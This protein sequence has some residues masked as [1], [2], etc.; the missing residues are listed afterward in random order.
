M[1]D[2]WKDVSVN[3]NYEINFLGDIRNK[4]TNK[5][6]KPNKNIQGYF[7]IVLSKNNIQKGY[8]VHRLVGLTFL[9]N[10]YN[11]KTINH[12]NK[13][14]T[15]NRLWNL[16]WNTMKE[17]NIHKNIDKVNTTFYMCTMK[18]IWRIDIKTNERLEKYNNLTEAQDW[19]IKNNLSTSK[20]VKN[21]ISLSALGNRNQALGYKWQYEIEDEIEN[22]NEIWKIIPESLINGY[23][24][25]YISSFGRIKY[26][27]NV[28]GN[29]YNFS[30]YLGMS[31]GGK[32]Y[33][34]HRLIAQTF[35]PNPDNKLVV[36][37]KDGDKLNCKLDNLEW[38]THKEN[39]DHAYI[40]YLNKNTKQIIL[41]DK[42]MNKIKDFN[43][44]NSASRELNISSKRIS[45]CCNKKINTFDD[46]IFLFKDEY[47]NENENVFLLPNKQKSIIQ[48]DLNF[49]IIKV[50]DSCSSASEELNINKTL[51]NDC[52]NKKQQTS[53]GFIFMYTN[54]Y[55]PSVKYNLTIKTKAKEIVQLDLN[56]NKIQS[57]SSIIKA[58]SELNL[59]DSS[60][61]LCC[62][63]KRQTAGGFKFM[64]I[65]DYNK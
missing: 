40:T 20:Y 14:K 64:Y 57:F 3:S 13:I 45:N 39:S 54:E 38:N 28:I 55:N 36:N 24:N 18:P 61:S 51:I 4:N 1:Y 19:C 6:L 46:Y 5:I 22:E 27:D 25:I 21:G 17:Q 15:D 48:F 35:L 62:K 33:K 42:N 53:K 56:M 34:A 41:F 16:E 60:I 58:A 50:F 10:Y 9:P 30:G 52:C 29:G 8:L 43:S 59:C 11:K 44:I 65:D 63:G 37:H 2:I 7:S 26:P 47:E 23:K 31:I 49:N 32:N 12:K